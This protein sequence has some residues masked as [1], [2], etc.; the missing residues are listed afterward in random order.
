ME[1]KKW[2]INIL[3]VLY[4]KSGM[5]VFMKSLIRRTITLEAHTSNIV[6]NVKAGFRDK[7]GIPPNH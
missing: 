5:Y 6:N 3:L 4:L 2:N 1:F 7:E